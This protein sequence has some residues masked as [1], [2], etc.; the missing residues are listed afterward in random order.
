MTDPTSQ[1]TAENRAL[2]A[3]MRDTFGPIP[4]WSPIRPASNVIPFPRARPAHA[5]TD[6]EPLI[7]AGPER[8]PAPVAAPQGRRGQ[9][10]AFFIASLAVHAAVGAVFLRTP[11]PLASVGIPS[12]SVEIVLG[13][14]TAAGL[15]TA[16]GESQVQSAARE[17]PQTLAAAEPPKESP[18]QARDEPAPQSTPMAGDAL[19]SDEQSAATTPPKP[20]VAPSQVVTSA[21]SSSQAT[22]PPEPTAA[23]APS[24][25]TE[26]AAVEPKEVTAALATTVERAPEPAKEAP[27]VEKREPKPPA[28]ARPRKRDQKRSV[29]T[30]PSNIASGIGRGRSDVTSNYHGL[31]AAH[32]ARNKRYPADAQQRRDQGTATVS[33]SIDGNGRVTSVRLVRSTGFASIDQEVQ[34]MVRRAS[35]F[36]AP[37]N[38]QSMSF[39]VPISFRL[40]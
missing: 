3:P 2:S 20:D 13:T 22:M 34:A 18:R 19:K 32:L 4:A 6:A 7:D 36:P 30:A 21:P 31:V 16:P 33:F 26:L 29:A 17:E 39:T 28:P 15:A 25:S 14:D 40:R 37:P 24:K 23:P 27:I 9:I 8:R 11:P 38:R 12:I 35:P 10:A 5:T 1:S